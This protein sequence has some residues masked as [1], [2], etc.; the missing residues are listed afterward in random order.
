[1]PFTTKAALLTV[2]PTGTLVMLTLGLAVSM[3]LACIVRF[4]CIRN[5]R[6]VP[7]TVT[8]PTQFVETCQLVNT[9]P[10]AGAEVML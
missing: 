7:V 5:C 6:F 4:D 8:P 9:K 3:K 10:V 2:R 1:M